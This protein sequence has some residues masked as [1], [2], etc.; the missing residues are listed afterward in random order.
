MFKKFKGEF[1]H[2]LYKRLGPKVGAFLK[3]KDLGKG[4]MKSWLTF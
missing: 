1:E 4:I 3:Y 2:E